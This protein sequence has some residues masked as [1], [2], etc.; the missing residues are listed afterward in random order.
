MVIIAV[1][2]GLSSCDLK[3]IFKA[4]EKIRNFYGKSNVQKIVT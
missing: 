3:A 1:V 2:V 4:K